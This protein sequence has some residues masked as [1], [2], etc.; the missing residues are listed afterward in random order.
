MKTTT[1]KLATRTTASLLIASAFCAST[2]LAKP[3]IEELSDTWLEAKLDTTI[4]LNRHLDTSGI[5]TDV[6]G[7]VAHL[8]GTVESDIERELAE[9]I[10]LSIEGMKDV[11]NE[12]RVEKRKPGMVE[13]NVNA[14]SNSV[15][16]LTTTA[17]IKAA[18]L[19]NEHL[20]G[21]DI[22]IDTSGETVTLKGNV[23][24]DKAKELA[25]KIAQNTD[26]VE[27]VVNNLRVQ[28]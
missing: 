21:L 1:L 20:D 15:R 28:S 5:D 26:G 18:F 7:Q 25:G 17:S 9:E 19:A 10:A 13:R 8:T 6:E 14:F 16:E 12:I 3:P 2:A 22:D 24:S 4:T 11:K 23:A 27:T